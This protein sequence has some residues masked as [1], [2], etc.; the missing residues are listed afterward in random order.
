MPEA[1]I[2]SSLVVDAETYPPQSVIS[3]W[4]DTDNVPA[5]IRSLS[6]CAERMRNRNKPGST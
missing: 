2:P 5:E 1:L 4:P 3:Q 6:Q